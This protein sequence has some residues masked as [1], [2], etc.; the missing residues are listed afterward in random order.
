MVGCAVGAAATIGIVI[1]VF[2]IALAL[3]PPAWVQIVIGVGLALGA[4]VFTWLV[5]SA[6]TPSGDDETESSK[7]QQP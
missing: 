6:W 4:T 7:G 3:Q 2:L 1:L 5:A